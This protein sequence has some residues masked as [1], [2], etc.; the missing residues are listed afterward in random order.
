MIC[1]YLPHKLNLMIAKLQI[2]E[3]VSDVSSIFIVVI[4]IG[5]AEKG[6]I[7]RKFA[8]DGHKERHTISLTGGA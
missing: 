8:I 6:E 7:I 2:K 1:C 5:P 3:A 4:G